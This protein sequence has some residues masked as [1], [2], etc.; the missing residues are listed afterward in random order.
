MIV[1]LLYRVTQ[2]LLSI[3]AALLRRETRETPS[4]WS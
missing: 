3:P 4:S 2:H 1:S